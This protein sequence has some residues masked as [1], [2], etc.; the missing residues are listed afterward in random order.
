[1]S[2]YYMTDLVTF[3]AHE[4]RLF[5]I[6]VIFIPPFFS[7]G[8][9]GL[10]SPALSPDSPRV[11]TTCEPFALLQLGNALFPRYLYDLFSLC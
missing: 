9:G 4:T 11:G 7:V 8:G 5:M 10:S 1:M 3:D 2:S 6:F